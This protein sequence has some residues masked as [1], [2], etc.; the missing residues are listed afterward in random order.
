MN[1]KD[2]M[3]GQRKMRRIN[4]TLFLI[5]I[6]I[7][8]AAEK[9]N[10]NMLR[11]I[12]LPISIIYLA[13]DT[14]EEFV[15]DRVEPRIFTPEEENT[16]INRV[17]FYFNGTSYFGEVIIKIFDREGR[18]IRGSLEPETANIMVWDGRDGNNKIVNGGI[19][20]YQVEADG[21]IINGTI[22]VAK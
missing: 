20:I 19:Y 18:Q 12:E 15:L 10:M 4:K 16:N 13:D 9:G 2:V 3:K 5:I 7:I 1:I 14:G 8:S 11:Q 6:G 22:V 21:K 17:R